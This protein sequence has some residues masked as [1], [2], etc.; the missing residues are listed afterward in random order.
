[1]IRHLK[2]KF[3]PLFFCSFLPGCASTIAMANLGS[4]IDVLEN[5]CYSEAVLSE[6][7]YSH[8]LAYEDN[9]ED[10]IKKIPPEKYVSIN[11]KTAVCMKNGF[12]ESG[13]DFGNV[14]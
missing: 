14:A 2:S 1:M 13:Y 12:Q 4:D 5:E 6:G 10:V 8:N 3:F 11:E 9:Q 7:F